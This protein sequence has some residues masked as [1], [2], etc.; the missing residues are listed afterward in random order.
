MNG[1]ET[2]RPSSGGHFKQSKLADM[3]WLTVLHIYYMKT[4]RSKSRLIIK[5]LEQG[6]ANGG[7]RAKDISCGPRR[8]MN[9]IKMRTYI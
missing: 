7:Q 4:E 9:I 1:F 8:V 2:I 5:G 6:W 3:N